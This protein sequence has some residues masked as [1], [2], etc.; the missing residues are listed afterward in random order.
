MKRELDELDSKRLPM[1]GR[2]GQ[3]APLREKPSPL[4]SFND[5]VEADETHLTAYARDSA[6]IICHSVTAWFFAASTIQL[7][8]AGTFTTTRVN[9]QKTFT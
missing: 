1:R 5:Q 8:D 2:R 7:I 4:S 6:R 9:D 3:G